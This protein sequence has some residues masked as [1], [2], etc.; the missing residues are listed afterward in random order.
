MVEKLAKLPLSFSSLA[1]SNSVRD[2]RGYGKNGGQIGFNKNPCGEYAPTLVFI[3]ICCF[4]FVAM[5]IMLCFV[6]VTNLV[7]LSNHVCC[8]CSCFHQHQHQHQCFCLSKLCQVFLVRV[9]VNIV[10]SIN[11]VSIVSILFC[12]MVLALQLVC[13]CMCIVIVK[14]HARLV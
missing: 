2:T 1:Q 10:K 6:V 8:F 4:Y 11:L 5:F 7:M 12:E 13:I 3:C 14:L 9:F